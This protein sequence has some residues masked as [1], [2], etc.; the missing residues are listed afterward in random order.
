[1]LCEAPTMCSPGIVQ[2]FYLNCT[3]NLDQHQ[4]HTSSSLYYFVNYLDSKDIFKKWQ[5][6]TT[7]AKMHSRHEWVNPFFHEEP[8]KGLVILGILFQSHQAVVSWPANTQASR[9]LCRQYMYI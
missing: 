1:M 6:Q 7:L 4:I 5:T 3:I 2:H 8:S 9:P